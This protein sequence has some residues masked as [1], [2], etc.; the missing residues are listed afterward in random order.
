VLITAVLQAGLADVE[1]VSHLLPEGFHSSL[2]MMLS[3]I[4]VD[5]MP[6]W[7][8]HVLAQQV[9][10]PRLEWFDWRV[11]VKTSSTCAARMAVPTCLLQMK[12]HRSSESA[13][14]L[15][16]PTT[17]SMEFSKETLHTM[18][19][20]LGRIRDQLASVATK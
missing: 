5:N 1:A 10:L 19:D 3:E 13:T 8:S 9:S 18:L 17:V 2:K 11:D 7:R 20:G 16:M 15:Q 6:E 4:I 14:C 12:V